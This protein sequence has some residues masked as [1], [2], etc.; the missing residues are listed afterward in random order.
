MA[1]QK[2]KSVMVDLLF[3]VANNAQNWN[4]DECGLYSGDK[5]KSSKQSRDGFKFKQELN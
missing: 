4:S 2:D 1:K 5:P 3:P